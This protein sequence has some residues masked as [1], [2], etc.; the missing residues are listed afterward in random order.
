MS[1]PGRACPWGSVHDQ[2]PFVCTHSTCH[3]LRARCVHWQ[4]RGT[5]WG[6]LPPP[7]PP[8]LLPTCAP[9]C[10]RRCRFGLAR[11]G[12]VLIADE[13]GVGKTVQAMALAACYQVRCWGWRCPQQAGCSLALE[14]MGVFK[15]ATAIRRNS[16]R[17][18]S[19]HPRH[20]AP[21]ALVHGNTSLA[22]PPPR[23]QDEWPLL[24]IAPA[25]MRLVW[26]EELE[27]WMPHLRPS[28]VWRERAV[29]CWARQRRTHGPAH[30]GSL[31]F[32]WEAA[33]RQGGSL[34]EPV[35]VDPSLP[36]H[37]CSAWHLHNAQPCPW[38][39]L[40]ARAD[41]RD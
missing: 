5:S 20:G 23:A 24:V 7:L 3:A 34:P 21:P 38:P 40:P 4:A 19:A 15:E 28:Q 17:P 31:H 39:A 25:S 18:A 9:S 22:H 8:L 35:A 10:A 12:R 13:M 41:P 36:S 11:G 33:T 30:A 37:Q 29:G 14:V 32:G 2:S 26:A 6:G 16:A 27:K 1:G